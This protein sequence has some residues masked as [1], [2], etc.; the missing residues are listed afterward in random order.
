MEDK[1]KIVDGCEDSFD[2]PKCFEDIRL[3]LL[4]LVTLKVV[5]ILREIV[6]VSTR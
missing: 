3:M 6:E 1:V 5:E 4:F 2:A